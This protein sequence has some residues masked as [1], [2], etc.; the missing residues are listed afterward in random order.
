MPQSRGSFPSPIAL[1]SAMMRSTRE[2]SLK[3]SGIVVRRAANSCSFGNG[4]EV[5]HAAFQGVFFRNGDQFT[6]NGGL[7]LDMTVLLAWFPLSI[8]S[9]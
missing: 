6:A 5:S 9:R 1:R 8:A 2:C 3:C 4:T 7:K